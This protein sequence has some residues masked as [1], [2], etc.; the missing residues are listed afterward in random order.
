MNRYSAAFVAV[1]LFVFASCGDQSA[2]PDPGNAQPVQSIDPAEKMA[3]LPAPFATADYAKG[4]SIFRRCASCH[5]VSKEAGHLVGPN[6]HRVFDRKVGTAEGF[7]YS[8]AL[9]GADFQWTPERLD[10]W[11][12]DPEGYLPGNRMIFVGLSNPEERVA[13]TAY[14]MAEAG[15]PPLTDQ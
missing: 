2:A 4:R 7:Q 5:L 8:S 11:L 14:L 10:A 12:V 6:L 9:S 13:V 15:W 1:S 3:A